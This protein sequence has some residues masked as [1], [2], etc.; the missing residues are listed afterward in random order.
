MTF[1]MK[2]VNE[3]LVKLET[4]RLL[5]KTRAAG[6]P[7][8]Q[9]IPSSSLSITTTPHPL[10]QQ[11]QEQQAVSLD[12]LPTSMSAFIP[13]S[14][15]IFAPQPPL[16]APQPPSSSSGATKVTGWSPN[17]PI[18]Q[19]STKTIHDLMDD[20]KKYNSNFTLSTSFGGTPSFN[21]GTSTT[22]RNDFVEDNSGIEFLLQA[23]EQTKRN[24][25]AEVEVETV[26]CVPVIL[27]KEARDGM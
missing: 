5:I 7:L 8:M 2:R 27:E 6:L 24:M 11:Q 25:D 16:A 13:A 4:L 18:S 21:G 12:T 26:L 14:T 1:R 9:A 3:S 10:L 15:P 17:I 20:R 19:P 23:S 22:K